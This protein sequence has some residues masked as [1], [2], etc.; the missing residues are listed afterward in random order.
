K[1]VGLRPGE[2]LFEELF[3]SCEEQ[4]DSEIPGIFE[5]RS[6]PIPLPLL[7]QAIRRLERLIED[8]DDAEIRRVV[9]NL[10]RIPGGSADVHMPFGDF[11]SLM[12]DYARG[13][14]T[15]VSAN[16]PRAAASGGAAGA[17]VAP[18]VLSD[19]KST[20]LNSSHVKIS[21]AV[22]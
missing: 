5:A 20:R 9:H 10:A 13:N 6:R 4:V 22:F 15:V 18:P 14:F 2:K 21:Y 3:D 16:A 8:G 12:A 1:V 19:R 17:P 11:G 7:A